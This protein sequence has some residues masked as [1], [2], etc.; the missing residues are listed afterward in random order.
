[1]VT[2]SKIKGGSAS[3]AVVTTV[4]LGA[5]ASTPAVACSGEQTYIGSVC[6]FAGNYCP[7]GYMK[8]EGQLL[9]ISQNTALFS[10]LGTNFG[11]DGRTN[12]A[13]PDLR[14]RTPVGLGEAHYTTVNMGTKRGAETTSLS[15][16]QLTAH[17]HQAQM[18]G[19]QQQQIVT[20]KVSTA[21]ADVETPSDGD[22]LAT[23]SYDSFVSASDAGSTVALA[24]GSEGAS[25]SGPLQVQ[26][27]GNNAAFSI[28]SPY[29]A[30]TYCIRTE[31]LFPP[32]DN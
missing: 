5:V 31:G 23:P 18:S 28:L 9:P 29:Q 17:N 7:D 19:G 27:T 26:N 21:S 14:G 32:R 10:L 6:T 15:S 13:L 3:V 4:F 30:A 24:G 22:Y 12:F 1:M 2:L 25:L 11:G 16:D 8:A 20:V